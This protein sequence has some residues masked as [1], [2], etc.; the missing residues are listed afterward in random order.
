[1]MINIHMIITQSDC[2][3][4][5]G[6]SRKIREAYKNICS[7]WT[8]SKDEIYLIGFSRGAFTALCVAQLINDVG[9]LESSWVDKE[10]PELFRLWKAAE[11]NPFSE[12]LAS[13]LNRLSDLKR[14]RVLLPDP[15]ALSTYSG[16][17]IAGLALWD[18]VASLRTGI[19]NRKTKTPFAFVGPDVPPNVLHVYHA[20]ALD[21]RR[22]D[23]WPMMLTTSRE[24]H[25]TQTWFR[26][27]HS[28]IG[29][30]NE[31]P[32]LANIA[33]CWMLCVLQYDIHFDENTIW[34]QTN[35]A[36]VL[37][38]TAS[39]SDGRMDVGATVFNSLKG[40]GWR[41]KRIRE[42]GRGGL[43]NGVYGSSG[44]SIHFSV[45]KLREVAEK[46]GTRVEKEC[47]ALRGFR[48]E[49]DTR[50]S[51]ISRNTLAQGTVKS[52]VACLQRVDEKC[53]RQRL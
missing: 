38:A 17:K 30:G 53:I 46:H 9:L 39:E 1:M 13:H 27:S 34:R 29:G 35:K 43:E 21:E 16:I 8:G 51:K 31:N 33:L 48:P 28:D 20:M 44:E 14:T 52:V 2:A 25:L 11:G 23:F 22:K 4:I 50:V 37:E 26:G 6:I 15:E 10:L 32:G 49:N 47:E 45:R 36:V 7:L 19:I 3:G 24:H 5:L 42:V 18:N 40:W 41:G 12:G